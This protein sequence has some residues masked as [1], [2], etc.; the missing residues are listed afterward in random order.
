MFAM[1]AGIE[2][3]GV[4]LSLSD[5]LKDKANINHLGFFQIA[6]SQENYQ[7]L[8]FCLSMMPSFDESP[9]IFIIEAKI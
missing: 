1:E 3:N 5:D 6:A 9:V 4:A 7:G 2:R 8:H